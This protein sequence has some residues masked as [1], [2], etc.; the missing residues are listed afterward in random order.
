MDFQYMKELAIS[1]AQIKRQLSDIRNHFEC[2]C[3]ETDSFGYCIHG[4]KSHRDSDRRKITIDIS[5]DDFQRLEIKDR[6]EYEF[7][8]FRKVI[9]EDAYLCGELR[10]WE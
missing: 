6:D 2:D 3:E 9:I 4:N 8:I 1:I 10:R 5:E 7:D